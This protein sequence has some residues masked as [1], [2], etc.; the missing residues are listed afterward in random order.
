MRDFVNK[1]SG[2]TKNK[3]EGRRPEGHIVDSRNKRMVETNRR[4]R[5]MEASSEGGH[6]PEGATEPEMEWNSSKTSKQYTKFHFLPNCKHT[7]YYK[8]E[9]VNVV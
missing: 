8:D 9:K 2:K 6:G 1:T 7:F 3:M 4:Q 5:R